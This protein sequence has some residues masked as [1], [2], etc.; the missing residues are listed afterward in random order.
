[1]QAFFH[2]RHS[3]CNEM[4]LPFTQSRLRL[5][6]Q[7]N[8]LDG[9]LL[10]LAILRMSNVVRQTPSQDDCFFTLPY[11]LI[12]HSFRANHFLS[13]GCPFSCKTL[14]RQWPTSGHFGGLC[15]GRAMNKGR[16]RQCKYIAYRGNVLPHAGRH[17][18]EGFAGELWGICGLI[19][20]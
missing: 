6:G 1:M 15:G 17:F 8:N 4:Y 3:S 16:H 14:Q 9:E 19:A 10:L 12:L 5:L 18:V 2:E 11:H 13:G 7:K 20:V